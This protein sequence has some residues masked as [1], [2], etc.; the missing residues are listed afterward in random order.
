M[1]RKVQARIGLKNIEVMLLQVKKE[2]FLVKQAKP[3]I[4]ITHPD[5]SVGEIGR[6]SLTGDSVSLTL[7]LTEVMLWQVKKESFIVKPA[8]LSLTYPP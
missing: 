5:Y 1:Y 8:S 2:S 4:N 6:G 3:F 7:T